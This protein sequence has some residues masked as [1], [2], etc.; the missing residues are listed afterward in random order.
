MVAEAESFR[1]RNAAKGT[2][3]ENEEDIAEGELPA[4]GLAA[5]AAILNFDLTGAAP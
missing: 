5:V 4:I 2:E 3:L 1:Q